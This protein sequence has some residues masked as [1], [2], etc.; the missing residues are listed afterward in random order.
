MERS[1]YK[2]VITSRIPKALIRAF[3]EKLIKILY[4]MNK[5]EIAWH[6]EKP[7]HINEHMVAY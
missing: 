4:K 1:F 6:P 7:P 2:W 5:K 3:F